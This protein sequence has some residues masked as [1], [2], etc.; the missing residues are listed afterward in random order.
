ME[1]RDM[2]NAGYKASRLWL[3]KYLATL[4]CWNKSAIE[5]R[6]DLIAGRFLK[7]WEYH[8]IT[9]EMTSDNGETNIFDADDPT[10]KRVEYMIFCNERIE[11]NWVSEY[12]VAIFG[13]LFELQPETFFTTDL[14]N[15]IRLSKLGEE[16][17]LRRAAPVND[18]Y[19]IEVSY[20]AKDLFDR[21]KH[22]LSIFDFEDELVIKYAE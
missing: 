6:F 3:N 21:I 9:V 8:N 22:A 11:K 2:E 20:S 14:G 15:R 12:Y 5:K 16:S 17:V 4:D 18:T 1:K 19:F 13:K 10:N 7:I